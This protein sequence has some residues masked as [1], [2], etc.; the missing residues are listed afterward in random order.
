MTSFSPLKI[1]VGG[2]LATAGTCLLYHYHNE[3]K[4]CREMKKKEIEKNHTAIDAIHFAILHTP[5]WDSLQPSQVSAKRLLGATSN[6]VFR[7]KVNIDVNLPAG[8]IRDV[9]LR[10]YGAAADKYID[11]PNSLQLSKLLGQAKIGPL[12][13]SSFSSGQVDE[14]V[15]GRK[16]T[17]KDVHEISLSKKLGSLLG[18]IHSVKLDSPKQPILAKDLRTWLSAA[19]CASVPRHNHLQ[20]L[21][22]SYD[23]HKL[24]SEVEWVIG[25]LSLL[26][27][28][29]ACCHNDL[30]ALNLLQRGDG[31]VIV[32]DFEYGG[33]NYRGYD[34]ANYFCEMANKNDCDAYP[35]FFIN[36]DEFPK[37]KEQD[38][39]LHS[40]L[41]RL[42]GGNEPSID[43]VE[44]LR[45]ESLPFILASHLKWALWARVMAVEQ[46]NEVNGDMRWGYLEYGMSRLWQYYAWK[47]KLGY[48]G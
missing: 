44:A 34:I 3:R 5:G 33:W 16:V 43:E 11:R 47:R 15:E 6:E 36:P 42:N 30:H 9:C 18:T 28:P 29:V 2:G 40:Y 4:K 1:L 38:V 17:S 48:V 21:V 13:L 14:F 45:K 20:Y 39:F 37:K 41:T 27:S 8:T 35:G 46:V 12:F 10:F 25:E 23:L 26:C 24:S 22:Q 19:L 32:L 31:S 7:V